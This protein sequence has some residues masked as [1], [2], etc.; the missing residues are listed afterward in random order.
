MDED[1]S[2]VLRFAF[3]VVLVRVKKNSNYSG[4]TDNQMPVVTPDPKM[5]RIWSTNLL[6]YQMSNY[7]GYPSNAQGHLQCYYLNFID[8]DFHQVVSEVTEVDLKL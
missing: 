7:V 4:G 2:V 3:D 8:F 5:M 1:S 6:H